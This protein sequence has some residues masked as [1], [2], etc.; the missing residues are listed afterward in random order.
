MPL[1]QNGR[2]LIEVG[3]LDIVHLGLP[4]LAKD[5]RH[6]ATA[7][8]VVFRKNVVGAMIGFDVV[9]F[10]LSQAR[11]QPGFFFCGWRSSHSE[12]HF[13]TPVVRASRLAARL[14]ADTRAACVEVSRFVGCSRYSR[15]L[16]SR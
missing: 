12:D 9:V 3:C 6:A 14:D 7:T 8:A 5:A 15:T 1:D 11:L 4:C 13:G 16:R 2:Y 10:D